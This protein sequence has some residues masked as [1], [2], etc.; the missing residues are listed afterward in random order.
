MCNIHLCES[1]DDIALPIA[2]VSMQP[3]LPMPDHKWHEFL[4]QGSKVY[5]PRAPCTT[6]LGVLKRKPS[7]NF[8]II[9]SLSNVQEITQPIQKI[10]LQEMR[11]PSSPLTNLKYATC[12]IRDM[13]K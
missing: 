6:I 10:L 5:N 13:S 9:N 8:L 11:H 1:V 2:Q 7:K 4:V 3:T 12:L